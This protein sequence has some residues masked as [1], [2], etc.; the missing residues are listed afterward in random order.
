MSGTST[1]VATLKKTLR[2]RGITYAEVANYLQLSEASVKRMFSHNHFTLDR[3]DTICSMLDL[4]ILDLIRI[5]DEDQKKIQNLNKEQEKELV[6]DTKFLLVALCIHNG[7]S[8]NEIYETYEYS[9]NECLSYLIRLDKLGLI[10]LL[11]NNKI[12]SLIAHDFEWLPGGPI[13]RFF[14]SKAQNEFL[15]S[16]FNI[17]EEKRIYLTGMLSKKSI[18]IVTHRLD[19][20]AHEFSYLQNDDSNL[21]FESKHHVGLLLA[22]RPWELSVFSKLKRKYSSPEEVNNKI[23]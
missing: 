4:D 7:L 11:P 2:S 3:V 16:G 17:P 20:L 21:P 22:I 5:V 19:V 1:L 8:F 15:N 23:I 14:V 18:D 13:E 9:E 12:R 6:S 10:Q